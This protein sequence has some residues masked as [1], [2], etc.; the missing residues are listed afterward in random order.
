MNEGADNLTI[1]GNEFIDGGEIGDV[2]VGSN[3]YSDDLGC[4]EQL[5]QQYVAEEGVMHTQKTLERITVTGQLLRRSANC[6][7]DVGNR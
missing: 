6:N 1:E 3:A 4:Q 2:W 5:V 7:P